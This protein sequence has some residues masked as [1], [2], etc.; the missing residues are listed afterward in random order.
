MAFPRSVPSIDTVILV[1]LQYVLVN[2]TIPLSIGYSILRKASPARYAYARNITSSSSRLENYYN[3]WSSKTH[4]KPPTTMP[5]PL[6]A[7]YPQKILLSDGSTF[8]SYTTAPTPSIIRLTRDVTNNPL[9]RPGSDRRGLEDGEGRV[10]KFRRRFEGVVLNDSRQGQGEFDEEGPGGLGV[11]K[12]EV[13]F[14]EGD[15]EWMGEGGREEN[16]PKIPERKSSPAKG[17]KRK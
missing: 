2:M 11:G 10:G 16:A 6:P 5:P 13:S 12:L 4:L 1:N 3:P 14:G 8:S 7:I 17:G 15:L 9:W